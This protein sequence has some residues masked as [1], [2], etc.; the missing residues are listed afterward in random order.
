MRSLRAAPN[1]PSRGPHEGSVDSQTMLRTGDSLCHISSA[2][3]RKSAR[4]RNGGSFR[5]SCL[6]HSR[7]RGFETTVLIVRT[8]MRRGWMQQDRILVSRACLC[9]KPGV[10]L[11]V[12]HRITARIGPTV[13]PPP[14]MRRCSNLDLGAGAPF[15][16]SYVFFRCVGVPGFVAIAQTKAASSPWRWRR[17]RRWTWLSGSSRADIDRAHSRD[18]R[19]PGDLFSLIGC[20]KSLL[21]SRIA[22]PNASRRAIRPWR[23][24][25]P[26]AARAGYP[27]S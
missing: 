11:S 3:G 12:G 23:L 13:P 4:F 26:C 6:A 25:P 8:L 22:R 15:F 18:L 17:R 21:R 10:N 7:R 24:R 20:G 2:F 27:P 1:R 19:L 16:D 14:A 5:M 9:L